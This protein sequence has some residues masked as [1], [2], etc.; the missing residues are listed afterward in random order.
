MND[1]IISKILA[2]VRAKKSDQHH[3]VE[4]DLREQA[5]KVAIQKLFAAIKEDRVEDFDRAYQE[6][7]TTLED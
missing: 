7:K 3:P 1:P 5:K 2:N 4:P 6:F